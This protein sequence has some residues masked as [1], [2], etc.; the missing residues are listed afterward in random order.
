MYPRIGILAFLLIGSAS[1][2]QAQTQAPIGPDALQFE[3]GATVRLRAETYD[4]RPF[5]STGPGD[6]DF[7]LWRALTHV[8]VS[9]GEAW[10]VYL[11]L[12]WHEQSGRDR[13]PT[14]TDEGDPDVRQAYVD[15]RVWDGGQVR[16][17]RQELAFGSSRLVSAR[18]GPN[19]RRVFDGALVDQQVG[20]WRAR[21]FVVRPV[22]DRPAAF[23]DRADGDQ[24]F[25]GVYA[26]RMVAPEIG[27]DVYYLGLGRE[28][29]RFASGSGRETRHSVGARLFGRKQRWDYN[30]EAVAQ[31]GS[32][33]DSQIR[34]WTVASDIGLTLESAPFAPR[35]GLKANV[36]SGDD[37]PSD[38]TLGTF[39]PLFPNL[40][41][42]NEAS[43]L[44]PQNHID[45]HP[46]LTL[47]L[48]PTLKASAGIDFFWKA[49][50]A[51]AVYRGPGI[52][53][54]G[55]G[56]SRSVGRQVDVNLRWRP[57]ARTEVKL[58][59][60]RLD[61]GRALREGGG[62]D[63]NFGMFSLQRGF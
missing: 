19:L 23:D 58:S 15:A 2:A 34:A 62:E 55:S 13:G 51:D 54:T 40:S 48:S 57:D 38:L 32:F 61:V 16:I 46:S 8:E 60:V 20:A 28:E 25:G 31:W 42:F 52:P 37:D 12:G 27:Y 33:G 7:V 24:L 47:N 30:V 21:A 59:Y 39:N 49:D 10:T 35:V 9:K 1:A 53:V 17:G 36:T 22:E 43:L 63:A 29:A 26:T 11:Q 45:I 14:P 44:S 50:A 5:G 4:G 56:R 6:E 41:Y 18:D 3:V